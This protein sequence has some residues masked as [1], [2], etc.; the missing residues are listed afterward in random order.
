MKF[1]LI[2]DMHL[3]FPQPKTP[4]DQLEKNVVVAGD[5]A[6]GL[7]GLKF[8]AKLKRKGFNVAACD[9]NHEH[10]SNANQGRTAEET[11]ARFREECPGQGTLGDVPIVLRNGWYH[12]SDES[13][14]RNYMNDSARCDLNQE[15]VNTRAWDDFNSIRTELQEWRDYQYRGI[16]VTHTAPCEETLDPRFWGQFS[17]EWYFN[18]YMRSLL[19]E[20]SDQILVWCHGHTHA[21]NEAIVSGVRVVCNPRGY[22]GENPAWKPLTIEV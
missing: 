15:Q 9:G 4:Y 11:T 22:P 18:P 20:F 1:S 6:N 13:L 14:W 19:E 3:D 21:R 8:L 17:N 12:V 16:V 2:S 5:T 10:Y 7:L